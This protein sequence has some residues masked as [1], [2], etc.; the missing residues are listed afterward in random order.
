MCETVNIPHP[1]SFGKIF[2]DVIQAADDDQFLICLVNKELNRPA[3]LWITKNTD[4]NPVV[5]DEETVYFRQQAVEMLCQAFQH[6]PARD[7]FVRTEIETFE[8][9]YFGMVTAIFKDDK[10]VSIPNAVLKEFREM[11]VSASS[12]MKLLNVEADFKRD[13]VL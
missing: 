3:T 10:H 5:S 2:Y 12:F 13:T 1:F 9:S 8:V 4:K 7:V 6:H 11:L